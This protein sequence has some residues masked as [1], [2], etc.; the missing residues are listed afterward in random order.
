MLFFVGLHQPSDLKR[1][2]FACVSIVRLRRRK[3]PLNR[4]ACGWIMDSGAFTELSLHGKYRHTA[5]EFAIDAARWVV[6]SLM[7]VVAQ[8][9]MCEPFILK[10]TGLSLS[11][12]QRLTIE[13]YDELRRAWEIIGTG[14]AY[15]P[16][17]IPVLQ[18]WTVDDYL[19]HLDA[20]GA[21]LKPGMW[22]GVG[23]VCK[24]QGNVKLIEAIFI[25]LSARR[26]DL[27]WHA[28]GIKITALKSAII[29]ALVYSAD[30]MAWSYS[31]RKQGRD[32]NSVQEALNFSYRV[33]DIC[34]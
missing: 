29:R 4:P 8:D 18:G 6:P 5:L 17:I 2:L 10:K 13:R 1:V 22:V 16:P 21:R 14:A 32:G 30:S 33:A 7:A 31:A 27:R 28:F 11:D 3:A 19:R 25:A 24:R 34:A 26:P 20:Y 15:W 9:Y 12:H 23:S